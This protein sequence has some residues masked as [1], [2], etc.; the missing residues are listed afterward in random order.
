[1]VVIL[2]LV[3][4]F[5]LSAEGNKP[6]NGKFANIVV[7]VSFA[8]DTEYLNNYSY[9]DSVFSSSTGASLYDY[10]KEVSYNKLEISSYFLQKDT[11]ISYKDKYSRNYYL[12]NATGNSIGYTSEA[13]AAIRKSE[14]LKSICSF[15]QNRIGNN[16]DIDLDNNGMVDNVTI[17]LK[18]K[19]EPNNPI[20]WPHQSTIS[21]G[22]Y[23]F[24]A[25][26]NGK[27]V[28]NYIILLSESFNLGTLCHEFFHTLGA[29]DLY[30]SD[31][32]VDPVYYWDLMDREYLRP[33][34]P[35]AYMKYR[36]GKWIDTIP[37]ITGYGEYYIYPL[38]HK[39]TNCYAINSAFDNEYL[40]LEYRKPTGKYES[41]LRSMYDKDAYK[42]VTNDGGLLI[43]RIN[44]TKSGE[45]NLSQTIG[46]PD[47]IY[48][49]RPDGNNT[50]NGRPWDALLNNRYNRNMFNQNT[51]PAPTRFAG[52]LMNVSISDIYESN[53]KLFFSYRTPNVTFIKYPIS[54]EQNVSLKPVI[55]WDLLEN[56]RIYSVQVSKSPNFDTLVIDDAIFNDSLCYVK[57]EL[58]PNT[59]Y[60]VR[61]GAI[62]NTGNVANWCKTM[63]FITTKNLAIQSTLSQHCAGDSIEIYYD[64]LG[65]FNY[66]ISINIYLLAQD[67]MIKSPILLK[68]TKID[69]VGKMFFSLPK[70]V[71]TGY[72][73]R[74][75]FQETN[76]TSSK[77]T[78]NLFRIKGLPEAKISSFDTILCKN[79]TTTIS[80]EPVLTNV[81][82]IDHQYTWKVKNG[83]IQK[84]ND[85][86]NSITIL[87]DN[88][89]EGEV[90]LIAQNDVKCANEYVRK[91]K[92]IEVPKI[93]FIAQN[94]NLL[95]KNVCSNTP[96]SYHL[97]ANY[98][99]D[100]TRKIEIVNGTYTEKKDSIIVTWS[101]VD[102]G[103]IRI[104]STSN[105][106]N[107]CNDTI[108]G[109]QKIVKMPEISII[110]N[111]AFCKNDTLEYKININN[112]NE[113]SI[114]WNCYNGKIIGTD[115]K[116]NCLITGDNDTIR[117]DIDITNKTT[118]C[119]TT[120]TKKIDL[121]NKPN[122]P[123]IS[124]VE[125]K[126]ECDIDATKYQWLYED[127]VIENSNSKSITPTDSGNYYVIVENIFGCRNKSLPFYMEVGIYESTDGLKLIQ[128]NN[129]IYIYFA[130]EQHNVILELYDL[131]GSKLL[132]E[133]HK[134][135]DNITIN[136]SSFPATAY[137]LRLHTPKQVFY[138]IIM[139]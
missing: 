108:L 106:S 44:K 51:N 38:T 83:T 127:N 82:N 80:F 139:K 13:E 74:L 113:Y 125:G 41:S 90:T 71:P 9:Y 30:R 57:S 47:E 61:V 120:A 7:F 55:K 101:N 34:H 5:C 75:L 8:N 124:F 96:I 89:G 79:T 126:L 92:I 15:I 70:N 4:S 76:D 17:I 29:K 26:I 20:M 84:I 88:V 46:I 59:I 77:V 134:Q 114:K 133:H 45:G 53:G 115:N 3:F 81:Q 16:V 98:Y 11:I 123:T 52:S 110:G 138:K 1:M 78:T 107:K 119:L 135:T 56:N 58:H 136:I 137:L 18:G 129:I 40:V 12:R 36:Y 39:D 24:Q 42:Y 112:P 63:T 91:I 64:Y 131:L 50:K 37:N 132:S 111:N 33:Q 25:F 54:L 109:I 72:K 118:N 117:L 73:Y 94:Q 87:W 130:E 35:S 66:N 86:N 104:I 116:N 27:Q 14:L 105:T 128:N 93:N 102:T 122:T 103:Y 95:E 68:N 121:H 97:V 31:K 6:N 60:Y 85:T 2:F 67:G 21:S 22:N 49:Y 19:T 65:N 62:E 28:M 43:Y 69:K 48:C 23:G 100:V 10:Y 32:T 99:S